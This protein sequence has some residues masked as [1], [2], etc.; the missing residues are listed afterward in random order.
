[1]SGKAE[2]AEQWFYHLERMTLEGA[3]PTLLE[4]SLEKGWT[5][6]IVVGTAAR[7]TELDQFLWTYRDDSFLPHG[8]DDEPLAEYQ[9][10]ILTQDVASKGGDIVFLID[11]ADANDLS[12]VSRCVTMVDSRDAEGRAVARARWSALKSAGVDVSYWRQDDNGRW[13]KA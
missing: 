7:L 4:K 11:G 8:R 6:R 5:A 10:I 12:G 2:Q 13:G 9:P 1:M 3:L